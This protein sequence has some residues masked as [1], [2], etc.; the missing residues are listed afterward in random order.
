MES[1][2]VD[3]FVVGAARSGTTSLH[4]YLGQHPEVFLSDVKELN[5][6]S[7]VE[8][9]DHSDYKAPKKG[10][11]YHTK[12]IKSFDVYRDLFSETRPDQIKGDVS[13]S[14]L[15][16][17][18]TAQRIYDHNPEARIII[19]L[20][21][22]VDRA[23]SHFV[24][25]YGV[26][27]DREPDFAKALKAPLDRVWGGGNLY[28]EWSTYFE[29]VKS[30]FD[31]F[32][33]DRIK[34]LIFEDWTRDKDATLKE[35]FHFLKI[36]DAF[37]VDHTIQHNQKVAYKNIGLLNFLRGRFIKDTIKSILPSRLRDWTKRKLFTSEEMDITLDA[38]LR[39][40]LMDYF[41]EDVRKLE[42]LT[43]IPLQEKW[44]YN[45]K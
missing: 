2:A 23:F 9:N 17:T 10:E 1:F 28:L 37:H 38:G 14:Y 25:N 44:G 6:F 35:L 33:K 39:E 13:P 40:E 18:E 21:N 31:V 15:W 26:G 12:I 8:S 22:P 16:G 34:L 30:Y 41:A 36:D 5:H 24:M 7:Q 20:R 27:Y 4:N 45:S 11:S 3:F 19:T 42:E 43:S 29:A 32:P